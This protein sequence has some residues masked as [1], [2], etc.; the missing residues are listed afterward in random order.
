MIEEKTKEIDKAMEFDSI[1]QKSRASKKT[2]WRMKT[3]SKTLRINCFRRE[4][5]LSFGIPEFT[6]SAENT[7]CMMCNFL[8]ENLDLK[9][10]QRILNIKELIELAKRRRER[11]GH[12]AILRFLRFP[13]REL[14]SGRAR[15]C[16][17]AILV[18]SSQVKS[19]Q[20]KSSLFRQGSPIS[21]RLETKD[22]LRKVKTTNEDKIWN[23]KNVV[24]S[25][26][27]KETDSRIL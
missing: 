7:F 21:H 17:R 14:G 26:L 1:M 9:K 23:L 27:N 11:Q 24:D 10:T 3:K 13:E 12:G 22:A 5:L 25:D 2:T 15:D 18:N 19:G 6:T 16:R 4:N 8:K 20:A